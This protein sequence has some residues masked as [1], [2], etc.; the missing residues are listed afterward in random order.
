MRDADRPRHE[1][2]AAAAAGLYS[3]FAPLTPATSTD[4]TK[5]DGAV[6][7]YDLYMR[8]MATV[9]VSGAEGG[10]ADCERQCVKKKGTSVVLVALGVLLVHQTLF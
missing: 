8:A 1:R 10:Q 7:F 9:D 6:H 3:P 4:R 2:E 5:K